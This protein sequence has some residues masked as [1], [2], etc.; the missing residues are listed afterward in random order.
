MPRTSLSKLRDE[1]LAEKEALIA[2]GEYQ[3][4][5]DTEEEIV[6]TKKQKDKS[7]KN[8]F[9]ETDLI[10]C[11]SVTVGK[12]IMIGVKSNEKYVWEGINDVKAVEYRDLIGAIRKH[13][14]HI[15]KPRIIVQDKEFLAQNPELEQ[16]YGSLYTPDDIEKI[17]DL[18]ADQ[19]R[20]YI[21]QMPQ[22]AK[23]A[24]LGIA[25]TQIERG[26]LDSVQRI[27]VLDE[28]FGTQLLLKVTQ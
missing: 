12:L 13:S 8:S 19:L 5:E 27:K 6:V 2:S 24:L 1:A 4:E 23:D 21:P 15:F 3:P 9:K 18:P 28:I 26:A 11:V 16:L 7:T 22:G 20:A 10:D 14:A 17:L 25:T